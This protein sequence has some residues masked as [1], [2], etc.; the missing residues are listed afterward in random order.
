MSS[1]GSMLCAGGGGTMTAMRRRCDHQ[2]TGECVGSRRP[3]KNHGPEGPWFRC[4][5]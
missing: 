2:Q 4:A 3:W 1:I 5:A